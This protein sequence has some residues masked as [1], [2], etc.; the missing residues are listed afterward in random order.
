MNDTGIFGLPREG[1]TILIVSIMLIIMGWFFYTYPQYF[2]V[3]WGYYKYMELSVL[4][5]FTLIFSDESISVMSNVHSKLKVVD[6]SDIPYSTI[7]KVE[8]RLFLVYGWVYS[9]LL[10]LLGFKLFKKNGKTWKRIHT[11]ET[12][13]ESQSKLWRFQR[14][15]LKYNPFNDSTDVTKGV[16]RI[17]EKPHLYLMRHGVVGGVKDEE[18]H[19]TGELSFDS[20]KY[21]EIL[22][23]QIGEPYRG[24]DNLSVIEKRMFAVLGMHFIKSAPVSGFRERFVVLFNNKFMGVSLR[25]CVDFSFGW[26]SWLVCTKTFIPKAWFNPKKLSVTERRETL[27]G[28][29]AYAYN[30]EHSF[31]DV[32]NDVDRYCDL[33]VE[34]EG[35]KSILKEHFYTRTLLRRMLFE[36]RSK[37]VLPT[38]YFGWLK[39]EDRVLWYTLNDLGLPESSVE[40]HGV[41]SHYDMEKATNRAISS[42]YIKTAMDNARQ[43]MIDRK[44]FLSGFYR[45]SSDEFGRWEK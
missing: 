32:K 21:Q 20:I 35:F 7:G 30:D 25:R 45:D 28:D 39:M 40:T 8:N 41:K 14:Y 23:K 42:P 43:Y 4:K 37:G 13:L 2:A 12:L 16:F 10:F 22:T 11:I 17:R 15:L 3:P 44:A 31:T 38:D 24:L 9:A 5:N 27:Y 6:F 19:F 33:I 18:G 26:W 36:S 34:S 1:E 29:I